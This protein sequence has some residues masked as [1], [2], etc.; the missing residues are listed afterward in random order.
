M[1]G[2][3]GST[4]ARSPKAPQPHLLWAPR[5]TGSQRTARWLVVAALVAFLA[6]TLAGVL[7]PLP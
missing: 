7:P 3:P 2:S 5:D 4:L 6:L 1:P